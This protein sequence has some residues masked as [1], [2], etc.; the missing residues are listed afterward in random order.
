MPPTSIASQVTSAT[1]GVSVAKIYDNGAAVVSF[2]SGTSIS[3]DQELNTWVRLTENWWRS[4]AGRPRRGSR[5]SEHHSPV[6]SHHG[7]ST[8]GQGSSQEGALGMAVNLG[9]H[10]TRMHAAKILGSATEFAST[11]T[12]YAGKLA[13][14]GLVDKAD[15]LVRELCGPV[16]WYVS[17]SEQL[18]RKG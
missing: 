17:P 3:W 12:S 11:L 10:E 18:D 9:A 8:S 2:A 13:D 16:F 6:H 7:S 5:G 14:D 1:G 15:E 4:A